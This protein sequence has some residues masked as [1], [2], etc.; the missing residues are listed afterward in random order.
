MF[1][2]E[3]QRIRIIPGEVDA[4]SGLLDD[5]VSPPIFLVFSSA[6]CNSVLQLLKRQNDDLHSISQTVRCEH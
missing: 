1:F 5:I 3:I 4:C 2:G 6:G